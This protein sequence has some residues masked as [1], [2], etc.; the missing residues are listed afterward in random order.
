MFGPVQIK[1]R[2]NTLKRYGALFTGLASRAIHIEMTKGMNTD[3][4]IL[5]LRRFIAKRGNITSVWCN[6]GGNFIGTENELEN[7][8]NEMGNKRIGN[9]LLDKGADWTVWKKNPAMASHMGGV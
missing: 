1:E 7:R 9:F 3:F 2:R 5:A 4:F 6:N 8:M